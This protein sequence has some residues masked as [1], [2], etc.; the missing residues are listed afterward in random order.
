MVLDYLAGADFKNRVTAIFD[1]FMAMRG[2]L[3]SEQ[4]AIQKI[5][6]SGKSKSS[7][8]SPTPSAFTAILQASS[9]VPFRRSNGWS[10]RR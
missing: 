6:Q 8:S 4:R 9:A 2:D 1:T 5:W 7:E 3:E 10:L